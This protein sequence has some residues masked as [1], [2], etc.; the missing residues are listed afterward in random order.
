MKV[1]VE[2][3]QGAAG[4]ALP[5]VAVQVRRTLAWPVGQATIELPAGVAAPAAGSEVEISV[6]GDEGPRQPLLS[7]R[8]ASREQGLT[9]ARLWVAERTRALADLHLDRSWQSTTAG[10]VIGELARAAS[11]PALAF[12]PGAILPTLT[13]TRE[14]SALD[15]ALRLARASGLTLWVDG[16]GQ[17]RLTSALPVPGRLRLDRRRALA[18]AEVEEVD[19][20]DAGVTVQ[21]EGA[22]GKRGFGTENWVLSDPA[23]MIAGDGPAVLS[24]ALLKTSADVRQLALAET[25]R[26][27]EQARPRQ[28]TVAEALTVDLFDVVRLAGFTER[29]E[30]ARVVALD[31]DFDG[32]CGYRCRLQLQGVA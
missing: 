11:V 30:A 15:H 4:P 28:L 16:R 31:T 17:L 14:R 12:S 6:A 2:V 10:S 18:E 21:G 25:S 24:H 23:A 9:G 19:A 5:T 26:R 3:R 32:R 8:V 7:G 1:A 29:E 22:L 13:L 20:G 27:R